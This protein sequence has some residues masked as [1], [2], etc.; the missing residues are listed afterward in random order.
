MVNAVNGWLRAHHD[1]AIVVLLAER[2]PDGFHARYD[3]MQ[4]TYHYLA[5]GRPR[6]IDRTRRWSMRP[7][8]DWEL[9]NRCAEMLL[10]THHFGSFC[11]TTSSTENRVCTVEQATWLP[12]DRP[13]DWRFVITANRF[14][15]GMVRAIVGTLAKIGQGRVPA[16]ALS[17]ILEGQDR[18]LAGPAAPPNALYLA[19]VTYADG[20]GQ[21]LMY[22][23]R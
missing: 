18:R 1:G 20:F 17:R 11:I 23:S 3:A 16:D 13:G 19:K 15:H 22:R 21:Q 8:P 5:T 4:R 10:G 14:L 6:A 7:E 12:E 2:A 9:M